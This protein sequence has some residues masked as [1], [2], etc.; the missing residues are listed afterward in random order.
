MEKTGACAQTLE[1]E[2]FMSVYKKGERKQK[3]RRLCVHVVVTL[4]KETFIIP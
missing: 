1:F 2:E 4:R 3:R